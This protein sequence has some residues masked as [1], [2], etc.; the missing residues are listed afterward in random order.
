MVGEIEI[1][2]DDSTTKVSY[3]GNFDE[4]DVDQE[5]KEKELI[6]AV[7]WVI[8]FHKISDDRELNFMANF[9]KI[10]F[11]K[12]QFKISRIEFKVLILPQTIF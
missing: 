10:I 12:C 7:S 4:E 11:W 2:N 1:A 9:Q 3:E 8:F 5:A 6:N